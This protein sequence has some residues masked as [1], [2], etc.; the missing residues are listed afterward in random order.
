MPYSPPSGASDIDLVFGAF[1]CF[2]LAL[3]LQGSVS[4]TFVRISNQANP[5]NEARTQGRLDT[6]SKA[7]SSNH[8]K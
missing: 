5:K 4:D 6:H 3:S 2:S 7:G 1:V 8:I